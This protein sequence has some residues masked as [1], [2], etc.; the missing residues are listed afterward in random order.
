MNNLKYRIWDS[1]RKMMGFTD[2]HCLITHGWPFA[3]EADSPVMRFSGYK[4]RAG[5]NIYESDIISDEYGRV[6][7]VEYTGDKFRFKALSETN[8][9]YATMDDWF[10]CGELP[11]V[12]GD[13][14]RTPQILE[15]YIKRKKV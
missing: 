12:I 1:K 4:D 7:L 14:Y 8:F 13:I 10:E 3:T 11:I 2:W 6:M 15:E 9:R 5:I